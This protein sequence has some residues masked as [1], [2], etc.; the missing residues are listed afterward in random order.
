VY[1]DNSCN[2]QSTSG[3][4]EWDAFDQLGICTSPWFRSEVTMAQPCTVHVQS[5]GADW[6]NIPWTRTFTL[7]WF[8]VT[9]ALVCKI[10]WLRLV[11]CHG[12]C[13]CINI[14]EVCTVSWLGLVESYGSYQYGTMS[15]ICTVPWRRY[16]YKHPM[17]QVCPVV[18]RLRFE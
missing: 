16:G 7:P 12:F 14:A 1:T 2:T 18:P 5:R 13:L 11:H 8:F 3:W 10:S 9:M 17:P 6:Y 4:G 15:H